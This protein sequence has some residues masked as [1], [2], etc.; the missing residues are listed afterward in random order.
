MTERHA[1][2]I[3]MAVLLTLPNCCKNGSLM[4]VIKTC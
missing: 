2:K 3:V 4:I 1:A